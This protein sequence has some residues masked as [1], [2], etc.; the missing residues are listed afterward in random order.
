MIRHIVAI[1]TKRGIAKDGVQPWKLPKDEAYFGEMTRQFG[2]KVLMGATT[3]KVIG[4]VLPDRKNFVVTRD[5]GPS[6]A[7][8]TAVHDIDAFLKENP[9]VWVIGGASIYQQTLERADELYIT[10]IDADFGCD[11]F[12]PDFSELFMLSQEGELQEENGLN[13]RYNI[14]RKRT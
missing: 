8:V 14:Y 2:G 13:F 4:I 6:V 7:G 3:F 1:D 12:Y 5:E 9:E 11:V 10:E